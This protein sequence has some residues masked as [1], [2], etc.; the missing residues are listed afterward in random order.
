[1]LLAVLVF[2]QHPECLGRLAVLPAL[3]RRGRPL[4]RA[5]DHNRLVKVLNN[6]LCR[7]LVFAW[8]SGSV[9]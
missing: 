5:L 7:Q 9:Y 1:V 2:L 8:K 4:V 3:E 6:Q